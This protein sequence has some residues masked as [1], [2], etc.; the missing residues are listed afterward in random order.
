[1]DSFE[2]NKI[3]AAVLSALLLIFGTPILLEIVGSG[4]GHGD[5]AAKAAYKLPEAASAGDHGG[6]QEKEEKGFEFNKVAA[7]FKEASVDAGKAVFKKC[8]ACHTVNDGGKNGQGPNLYD[9][10]GRNRAAIAEFKYSKA[11]TEKAGAWD[12]AS[13][14]GFLHKPKDYLKGTKMAFQG[15]KSDKD[16]ANVLVYLQSLSG[17][18]KP[19]PEAN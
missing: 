16:L 5:H 12:Y 3:A 9:I 1:M 19:L 7:L 17:S 15:L 11:M 2:F 14:A 18:P 13:L 4:G 8:A 6:T 10:V